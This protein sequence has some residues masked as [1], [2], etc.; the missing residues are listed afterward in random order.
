MAL[1]TMYPAKRGSPQTTLAANLAADATSMVLFDSSVLP[2][3]PNIAVIGSDEN[4]EIVSYTAI[5][6]STNTVSGLI[7]GVGGSTPTAWVSGTGV[8][9]NISSYDHDTFKA[10]ISTLDSS[11]ANTADLGTMAYIDDAPASGTKTYGRQNGDWF[12]L[13]GRYYNETEIR[14]IICAPFSTTTNYGIGDYVIQSAKL[15][16]FT[17]AH[18]AGS[19]DASHVMQVLTMDE[20]KNA[21]NMYLVQR[22]VNAAS[23]AQIMRIP[24]SGTDS[25]I[26]TNTI[27]LSCIFADPSKIT[28]DVSWTSNAGY[29]TFN[30]TCT[31]STTADVILVQ[32][33]N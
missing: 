11:K 17:T 14:A 20:V 4:C 25:R 7:R 18:S 19:W 29:V 3:A 28:S 24:T 26:T 15:F 13:D 32:K 10:N 9:R 23:N 31:A 21:K 2:E 30:G 8:A 27:V 16:R 5:N 22:T 12:D 6:S 33:G 1:L